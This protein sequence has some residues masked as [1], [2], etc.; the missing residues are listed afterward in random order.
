MGCVTHSTAL[1]TT[2][3]GDSSKEQFFS[4]I[5][6]QNTDLLLLPRREE[7]QG[8]TERNKEKEKCLRAEHSYL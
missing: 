4:G 7:E 3:L 2:Y 1:Q 5:H 8:K 6:A